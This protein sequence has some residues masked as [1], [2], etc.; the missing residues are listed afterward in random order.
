MKLCPQCDQLKPESDFYRTKRTKDGLQSWCKSCQKAHVK[1]PAGKASQERADRNRAAT[2]KR[3]QQNTDSARRQRQLQPEK[4]KAR[5]QRYGESEKGK[6]T[7]RN[8]EQS[9]AGWIARQ[10]ANANARQKPTYVQQTRARGAVWWATV[11]GD[12]PHPRTLKCVGC[13]QQASEYHH[14]EGYDEQN[15]LHVVP[16]CR[17]CHRALE[18]KGELS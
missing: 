3:V 10:R 18:P 11:K 2:P 7:R 1:S 8:Y 6:Q 14:H 12:L 13:G 15:K 17:K 4:E 5:Q 9:A 16:V